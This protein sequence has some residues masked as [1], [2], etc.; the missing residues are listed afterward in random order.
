MSLQA[1]EQGSKRCRGLNPDL[2]A[3]WPQRRRR[4]PNIPRWIPD[5][6]ALSSRLKRAI[7]IPTVEGIYGYGPS[8]QTVP[9]PPPPHGQCYS[10][11]Y[12]PPYSYTAATTTTPFAVS[13]INTGKATALLPLPAVVHDLSTRHH[14]GWDRY[15]GVPVP[16]R[17]GPTFWQATSSRSSSPA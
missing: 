4:A 8:Y 3:P 10:L 7:L 9:L 15:W 12:Y 13:S 1:T 5:E 17:K 2:K 14:H 11:H 16:T 6:F